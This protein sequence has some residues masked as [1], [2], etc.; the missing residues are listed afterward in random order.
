MKRRAGSTPVIHPLEWND[1]IHVVVYLQMWIDVPDDV[2]D[3]YV[4]DMIRDVTLPAEDA[5]WN[6]TIEDLDAYKIGNGPLA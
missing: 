3:S 4:D 5:G 2:D 1:M 6:V